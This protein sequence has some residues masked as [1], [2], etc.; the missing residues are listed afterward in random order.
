MAR[1]VYGKNIKAK[2]KKRFPM[3]SYKSLFWITLT[4]NII[5]LYLFWRPL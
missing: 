2:G 4:L 5:S 1:I 3:L